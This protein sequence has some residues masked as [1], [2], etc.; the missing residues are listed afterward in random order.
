MTD[1]EKIKEI[2][3]ASV[4]W[5]EDVFVSR[6]DGSLGVRE[7][8][9]IADAIV[10]HGFGD[11][12]KLHVF[13]LSGGGEEKRFYTGEEVER[14]VQERGGVSIPS[15]LMERAI[16]IVVKYGI[17]S[18]CA[19]DLKEKNKLKKCRRFVKG[20]RSRIF[21]D[22]KSRSIIEYT[23]DLFKGALARAEREFVEEQE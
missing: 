17:E 5:E 7:I 6:A 23:A 19:M 2:I 9:K 12:G 15:D 11:M 13:V 22:L 3:K 14:I 16:A 20:I 8:E 18:V 21:K 1:R 4:R 10:E